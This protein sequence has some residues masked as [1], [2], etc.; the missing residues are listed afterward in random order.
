MS[1]EDGDA[2]LAATLTAAGLG[3]SA[4]DAESP[5]KEGCNMS[6]VDMRN[7]LWPYTNAG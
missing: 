4:A 1:D 5:P 7:G 2:E 6:Y 3:L